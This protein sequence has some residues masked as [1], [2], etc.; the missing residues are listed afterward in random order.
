MYLRVPTQYVCVLIFATLTILTSTNESFAR[1][2]YYNDSYTTNVGVTTSYLKRVA[3]LG[4][5]G[6]ANYPIVRVTYD[7]DFANSFDVAFKD[8]IRVFLRVDKKFI[9]ETSGRIVAEVKLTNLNNYQTTHVRFV[10]VSI[11]PAAGEQFATAV[12]DVTNDSGQKLVRPSTVYRLFVNLHRESHVYGNQSI[13]G[14]LALPYYVATGGETRLQRARQQIVMRTFREFYYR[15]NGWRTGE[16]YPMDCYA[17]YMWATGFC[18][19]GAENGR[20]KLDKLFTNDVPYHNGSQIPTISIKNTI[21][22]DYV[23]KP[24]HSFMLLSYDPELK[25][26][27]CME[28]NFRNT[29]EVVVRSVSSSWQVGHLRDGHIRLDVFPIV[30]SRPLSPKVTSNGKKGS[31]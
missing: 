17:Y 13:I 11:A 19:T 2:R 26:V 31:Q 27:W 14:R 29:V 21:H 25:H 4:D 20:T 8:K 16:H 3:P 5:P 9:S 22:G 6:S 15:K 7:Y 24:G 23:R 10:P 1:R 18:T 28:G 30:P 12:F